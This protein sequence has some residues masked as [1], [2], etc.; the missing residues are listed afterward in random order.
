MNSCFEFDDL[1]TPGKEFYII[2]F[3]L[4]KFFFRCY[5]YKSI[6]LIVGTFYFQTALETCT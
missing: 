6:K 5:K 1:K 3:Y 4:V 2:L